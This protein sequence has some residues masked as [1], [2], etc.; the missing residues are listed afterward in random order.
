VDSFL[1]QDLREPSPMAATL[2]QLKELTAYV[3]F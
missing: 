2:E 1:R 3:P